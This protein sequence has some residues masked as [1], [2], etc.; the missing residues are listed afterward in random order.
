[1]P[2]ALERWEYLGGDDSRTYPNAC[3]KTVANVGQIG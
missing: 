2:I 3:V 1:M